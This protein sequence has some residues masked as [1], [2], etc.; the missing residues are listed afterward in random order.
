[1]TARADPGVAAAWHYAT[2]CLCRWRL[3][4]SAARSAAR[5]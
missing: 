3:W 2:Q 1:M 5:V 4:Q